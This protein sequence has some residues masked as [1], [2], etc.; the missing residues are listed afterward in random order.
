MN[1][2]CRV[3]GL[4]P[5]CVVI[6]ATVRALKM[7]GGGPPVVAGEVLGGGWC[8]GRQMC[9]SMHFEAGGVEVVPPASW[10]SAELLRSGFTDSPSCAS[11]LPWA[12]LWEKSRTKRSIQTDSA[13]QPSPKLLTCKQPSSA[14]RLLSAGHLSLA[15]QTRQ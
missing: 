6:V 4:K 3:S 10:A 13:T 11:T 12:S 8:G 9:V 15:N 7:H 2:K 14:N 1:I 5:N